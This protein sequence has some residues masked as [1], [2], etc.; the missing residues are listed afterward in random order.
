MCGI[1]T[2]L[3][4]YTNTVHTVWS[5]IQGACIPLVFIYL[6]NCI[7]IPAVQSLPRISICYTSSLTKFIQRHV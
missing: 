5:F 2:F 1:Y 4:I 7:S 3:N 6:T